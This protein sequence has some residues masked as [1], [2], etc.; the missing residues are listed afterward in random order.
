MIPLICRSPSQWRDKSNMTTT[1]R[2]NQ[3]IYEGHPEDLS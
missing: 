1:A 3:Q 2:T